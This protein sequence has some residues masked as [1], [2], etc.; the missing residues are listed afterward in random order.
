MAR[1]KQTA[2]R[3]APSAASSDSGTGA[4]RFSKFKCAFT[5]DGAV[6]EFI[7]KWRCKLFGSGNKDNDNDSSDEEEAGGD[8]V[9]K[10]MYEG[11]DSSTWNYNWVDYPPKQIS[12][13]TAREHG[14]VA[15][16]VFKVKDH[17]KQC[18]SG[19]LP[20]K[21]H[22]IQVQN[23]AV[24]A[25]LV[26]ILK[27]QDH[28]VSE[29]ETATF[30]AP[31]HV[32]FFC[33]DE[34]KQLYNGLAKD[35]ILAPYLKLFVDAMDSVL[36]EMHTKLDN[37]GGS[38]LISFATAWTLFS[39]GTTL[40]STDLE[41][42]FLCKVIKADY[43]TT[44]C[45]DSFLQ[46]SVKVLRFNGDSFVWASKMLR[47]GSFS[48][49]KPIKQ[50][51]HYPIE[52]HADIA[53]VY[54]RLQN[55]GKM[56]LDLQ[57]LQYRCY[58]NVALYWQDSKT[59]SKH[60]VEGRILIDVSGY[61]KYQD[62]DLHRNSAKR[63]SSKRRNE[64]ED[65][66]DDWG[67]GAWDDESDNDSD[68]ESINPFSDTDSD[69][70]YDSDDDD[71]NR[72]EKRTL[73]KHIT[74][75]QCLRNKEMMLRRK[76]DLPFLYGLVGGYAL[77]TKLW[78][79]FY[80][81]DIEP[82][83]WNDTAYSHLVYD[84]QQKDLILSFVQYH[85]FTNNTI[86]T[87]TTTNSTTTTATKPA[88]PAS[89]SS[90]T[91]NEDPSDS[92]STPKRTLA[93]IDD[94]IAGKGQGLVILLSGPPGTGKTLMAEAVADRTHRPLVY[95][96]AEDLGTHAGELGTRLKRC[97]TM[98]AEW[99]AV[100]LLDEADVFMAE[101]DP[102]NIHRNELV[103]IF[104]RELEYFRGILFLTT[105]LY[106]TIDPA[107]RSRVSLHLLFASLP[108]DARKQV[109][110]NFLSRLAPQSLAAPPAAAAGKGKEIASEEELETV[111]GNAV[112]PT[113]SETDIDEISLWQLNGR[114][115]K[116][117]VKMVRTWCDH[118]NYVMTLDRLE[119]G[120][121]VTNPCATKSAEVDH[122]L[123]A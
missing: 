41:S 49:N 17:E 4:G 119:S 100:V 109:W 18:I 94:V 106:Q 108:R 8:P 122:D 3:R 101:R 24:V 54:D 11:P 25:A 13:A 70:S 16:K 74:E 58:N 90:S 121:R 55:R 36:K 83:I 76:D 114:E 46:I 35:D 82:L 79:E 77:K 59:V 53:S 92:S 93:P 1:T 117:A 44:S 38:S 7:W 33:Q 57:G 10:V 123:Y 5:K 96:Q 73:R 60:N 99:N 85:S 19:R 86:A 28:H 72:P 112:V 97:L 27:K 14:R 78:V 48:G 6:S 62:D 29:T 21:Y 47:L 81:E 68:A 63:K 51:R 23:L 80:I 98:A 37:L 64:D 30:T 56:M 75:A 69:N 88:L 103:S 12:K 87:P 34:I 15:I 118:K 71:A 61:Q 26:P 89:D 67:I 45:G 50:L 116:N 42:E 43:V 9:S 120:I 22:S 102:N 107:F 110:R 95:L 66:Q 40:Y 65:D 31:F 20:L 39:R 84:E 111:D 91:A 105:N 32:L 115:I 52:H 113:L 2:R 104:L